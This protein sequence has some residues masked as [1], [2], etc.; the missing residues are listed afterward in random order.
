MANRAGENF[1]ERSKGKD[2]RASNIMAAK[3][4]PVEPRSSFRSSIL[5]LCRAQRHERMRRDLGTAPPT[6]A[7]VRPCRV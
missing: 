4:S 3:V 1:Q 6:D 5:A 7:C 2:V